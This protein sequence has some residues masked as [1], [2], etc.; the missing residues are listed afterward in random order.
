MLV[1]FRHNGNNKMWPTNPSVQGFYLDSEIGRGQ[2]RQALEEP[3]LGAI[4]TFWV[5]SRKKFPNLWIISKKF[6]N[7]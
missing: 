6:I 2:Y 3:V 4:F 5:L 7:K 1:T